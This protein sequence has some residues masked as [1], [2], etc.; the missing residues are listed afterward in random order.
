MSNYTIQMSTFTIQ[1]S[2]YKIHISNYTI[3]IGNYTM[4]MR[5]QVQVHLFRKPLAHRQYMKTYI[6]YIQY[7]QSVWLNTLGELVYK[8]IKS[9][10]INNIVY[11]IC[12]RIGIMYNDAMRISIV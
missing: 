4:R 6:Q 10:I 11:M 2:N 7:V 8:Y 1:I 3:Q 9:K 12:D 5:V